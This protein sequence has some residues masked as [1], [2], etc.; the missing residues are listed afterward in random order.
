MTAVAA[1][2]VVDAAGATVAVPELVTAVIVVESA[3]PEV[4][5]PEIVTRSL[6]SAPVNDAVDEVSV[7]EP[8]LIAASVT[9]RTRTGAS[10]KPTSRNFSSVDVLVGNPFCAAT[11]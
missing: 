11:V 4:P 10:R 6:T 8:P 1:E 7:L 3:A 2:T 9:V 5:A